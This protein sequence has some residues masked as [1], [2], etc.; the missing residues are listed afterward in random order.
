[1]AIRFYGHSLLRYRDIISCTLHGIIKHSHND[2]TSYHYTF[3]CSLTFINISHNQWGPHCSANVTS[4][5]PR[6]NN[7][8]TS[9]AAAGHITLNTY[10]SMASLYNEKAF[11]AKKDQL[12]VTTH[13]QTCIGI[14]LFERQLAIRVPI[15]RCTTAAIKCKRLTRIPQHSGVL[16]R[17]R[18]SRYVCASL[19]SI[20]Q[21]RF[22]SFSFRRQWP[23]CH[24]ESSFPR[25]P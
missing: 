6:Y 8:T 25:Q 12:S 2:G 4:K 11:G 5:K 7:A 20:I 24:K 15:S 10:T 17:F 13:R 3:L 21:D 23:I 1:M 9:N 18:Y 22:I 16:K 14:F 19:C